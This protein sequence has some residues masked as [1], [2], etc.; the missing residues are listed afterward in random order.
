MLKPILIKIYIYF[1]IQRYKPKRF[2]LLLFI[3]SVIEASLF[4]RTDPIYFAV[5]I[6]QQQY[7]ISRLVIRYITY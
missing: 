6:L 7:R 3:V 2:C 4:F 5:D 1:F